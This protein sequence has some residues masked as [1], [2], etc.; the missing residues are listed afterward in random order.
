MSFS[1]FHPELWNPVWGVETIMVGL[2]SFMLLEDRTNGSMSSTPEDR[3]K[4]AEESKAFN[5]DRRQNP[6]FI[7]SFTY[8]QLQRIGVFK[9]QETEE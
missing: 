7:D 8:E 5:L 6:M 2:I 1:N 3:R 9:K 4:L